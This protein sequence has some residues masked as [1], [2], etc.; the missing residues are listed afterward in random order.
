MG[1][2]GSL[3]VGSLSEGIWGDP[4]LKVWR[5]RQGR[6]EPA[7]ML[8][9]GGPVGSRA[10]EKLL[11][12]HSAL[13]QLFPPSRKPPQTPHSSWNP[14]PAPHIH[15]GSGLRWAERG[16]SAPARGL[17]LRPGRSAAVSVPMARCRCSCQPQRPAPLGIRFQAA[18]AAPRTNERARTEC[19]TRSSHKAAIS[20]VFRQALY[21]LKHTWKASRCLEIPARRSKVRAS[22]QLGK[23][24]INTNTLFTQ[25]GTGRGAGRVNRCVHTCSIPWTMRNPTFIPAL[26]L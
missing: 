5:T 7:E 19:V 17:E 3:H 22:G 21:L 25:S 2:E 18:R 26:S 10:R 9:R 16:Q 12:P 8:P 4:V 6:A 24:A 20:I 1:S 13:K 11:P 15:G 14:Q 23:K